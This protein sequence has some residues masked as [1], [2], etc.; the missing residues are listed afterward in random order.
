MSD[1]RLPHK[2]SL[3]P[4]IV[5]WVNVPPGASSAER[6]AAV[7]EVAWREM[8]AN[9]LVRTAIQEKRRRYQTNLTEREREHLRQIHID[10]GFM[11]SKLH[12]VVEAL[13]MRAAERNPEVI[14]P[15]MRYDLE[16]GKGAP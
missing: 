9:G 12:E 10:H 16:S 4:S 5:K 15:A 13:F 1:P 7:I 3:A 11:S 2:I 6:V 8:R 14:H